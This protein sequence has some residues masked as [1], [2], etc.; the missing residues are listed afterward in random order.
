M[1]KNTLGTN[2]NNTPPQVRGI[3]VYGSAKEIVSALHNMTVQKAQNAMPK[4]VLFLPLP[5]PPVKTTWF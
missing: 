5:K 2:Q 1:A 4:K 3:P